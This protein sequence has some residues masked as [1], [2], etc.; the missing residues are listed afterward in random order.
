MGRQ[1]GAPA[2]ERRAQLSQACQLRQRAGL[3]APNTGTVYRA[4]DAFLRRGLQDFRRAMRRLAEC[5]SRNHF[6]MLQ[7][8][9]DWESIDLPRWT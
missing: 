8:D 2:A 1:G 4:S 7:G 3:Q 6:P 5:R 9:G